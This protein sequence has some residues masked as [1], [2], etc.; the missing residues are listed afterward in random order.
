MVPTKLHDQCCLFQNGWLPF[1]V[2]SDNLWTL[3]VTIQTD[4]AKIIPWGNSDHA[5]E[6]ELQ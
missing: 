3:L 1:E 5:R 2:Q 4:C 6:I